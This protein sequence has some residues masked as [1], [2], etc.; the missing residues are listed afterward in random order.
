MTMRCRRCGK[1]RDPNPMTA[2]FG[3]YHGQGTNSG[4]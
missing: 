3:A 1:E 2:V 4:Y